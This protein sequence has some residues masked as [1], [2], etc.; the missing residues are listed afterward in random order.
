VQLRDRFWRIVRLG[1]RGRLTNDLA[2]RPERDAV[3]VRQTVPAQDGRLAVSAGNERLDEPGLA[4]AGLAEHGDDLAGVRGDG[5]VERGIDDRELDLASDHRP[6][7]PARDADLSAHGVQL[8]RRD[9]LRLALQ[10]ERLDGFDLDRVPHQLVRRLADEGLHLAG[11]LLETRRDVDRIAGDEALSGARVVG[12]DL[13]GVHA[14]PIGERRAPARHELF[15]QAL[16][17][18]LHVP[19]GAARPQRVV[20]VQPRQAED[21]HDRIA[22][23]L[24]D[25]PA[26]TLDDHL[27]RVEVASEDLAQGF[28][29]EA[30]AKGGGSLEVAEQDGDGL[31]DFARQRRDQRRPAKAA[32]PELIRI[33][34]ATIWAHHHARKRTPGFATKR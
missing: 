20:L 16:E 27:H 28:R 25:R 5:V 22:D 21:R 7:K 30:F 1:D 11:R 19:R 8:V 4:Q 33:V 12:D 29:V 34:L 3:A 6:V 24:F 18:T 10:R 31:A 17:R 15:V 13:A 2:E 26:V 14:D 32:Y 23:E 9:G